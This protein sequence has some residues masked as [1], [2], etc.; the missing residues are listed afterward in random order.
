MVPMQMMHGDDTN[1]LS[2][3]ERRSAAAINGEMMTDG[4]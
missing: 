1:G 2:M 3:S 4:R